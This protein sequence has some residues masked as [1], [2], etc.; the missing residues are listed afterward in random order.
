MRN[1]FDDVVAMTFV[2]GNCGGVVD[3]GLEANG[4]AVRGTQAAL[5]GIEQG[6]ADVVTA[7]F[8][9][10]IDCD[11]VSHA[12]TAAFGNDEGKN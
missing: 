10:N 8:A 1:D 3:G 2:E 5:G 9:A 7:S 11:D 12:A 6:R 4:V